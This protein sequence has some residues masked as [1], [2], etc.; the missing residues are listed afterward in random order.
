MFL[1]EV[2]LGKEH[3]ITRDD[4]SLKAAPQGFDSVVAKGRT[5]PGVL[6]D[7]ELFLHVQH[8]D[9]PKMYYLSHYLR[10]T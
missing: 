10:I 7:F 4:S 1:C 8:K 3:G 6:T 9:F 5:E 2:A